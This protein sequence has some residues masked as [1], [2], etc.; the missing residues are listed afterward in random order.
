[1]IVESPAQ[2]KR[3][4]GD[5]ELEI[6]DSEEE[7]YGWEDD[8]APDLPHLP[9]QWQGSEDLLLGQ[10]KD[11]ENQTDEDVDDIPSQRRRESHLEGLD[12]DTSE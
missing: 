7:D 4:L 10:V 11:E 8:D 12:L 6:A 2:L 3:K 9:P 5:T 1:V